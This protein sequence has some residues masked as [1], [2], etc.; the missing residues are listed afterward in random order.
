MTPHRQ[1]NID[2]MDEQATFIVKVLYRENKSWQGRV[3]WTEENKTQSFRSVLELINL[4]DSTNSPD[5][6]EQLWQRM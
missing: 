4:I 1:K 3:T 2:S 6:T 5:R